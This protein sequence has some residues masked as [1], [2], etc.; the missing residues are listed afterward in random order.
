MHNLPKL[1]AGRNRCT[2]LIHPVDAERCSVAH[3]EV[4]QVRS[5]AG[6]IEVVAEVTDEM[7]PGVVCLP[8]GWG[9]DRPGAQLE[10]A[11]RH[12]GVNSNHL[13]PGDFVDEI[14]G[15]Q[16]VNGIPVEVSPI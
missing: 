4:T 6:C 9:H 16:A 15:N 8:H 12:A 2:L 5:R 3:D 7:M 14:S 1:V 11:A 10:V 13:S